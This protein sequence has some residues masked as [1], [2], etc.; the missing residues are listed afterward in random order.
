MSVNHVRHPWKHL[1][2]YANCDLFSLIKLKS[3]IHHQNIRVMPILIKIRWIRFVIHHFHII[4]S[5]SQCRT[6]GT[7]IKLVEPSVSGNSDMKIYTILSIFLIETIPD[8]KHMRN[9]VHSEPPTL[10]QVTVHNITSICPKV[11]ARIDIKPGGWL[12]TA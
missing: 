8:N 12:H 4:L 9:L 1:I 6:K 2:D 5:L 11:P 3:V 7:Y 10:K